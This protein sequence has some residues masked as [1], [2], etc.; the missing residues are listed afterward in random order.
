MFH[1]HVNFSAPSSQLK[2][3]Q[4]FPW[5][6]LAVSSWSPHSVL[7]L[8]WFDSQWNCG[9]HFLYWVPH[10]LNYEETAS[11]FCL[12]LGKTWACE[13]RDWSRR[14]CFLDFLGKTRDV[15]L[16]LWSVLLL[17]KSGFLGTHLLNYP[18][19]LFPGKFVLSFPPAANVFFFFFPFLFWQTHF[20]GFSQESSRSRIH[21]LVR[22]T[23]VG[24]SLLYHY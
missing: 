8:W 10:L 5:W 15:G 12:V 9:L 13:V 23:K 1:S 18:W 6:V 7:V 3:F 11:G 14:A 16:V 4:L 21:A 20:L 2:S 22:K 19:S 17:K 24:V